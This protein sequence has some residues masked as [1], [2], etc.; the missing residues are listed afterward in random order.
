MVWREGKH[1]GEKNDRG[2]KNRMVEERKLSQEVYNESWLETGE[3]RKGKE[4]VGRIRRVSLL[5]KHTM[6]LSL[7]SCVGFLPPAPLTPLFPDL[8]EAYLTITGSARSRA[9]GS[10]PFSPSECRCSCSAVMGGSHCGGGPK[11]TGGLSGREE[12]ME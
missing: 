6:S 10:G 2:R 3:R 7:S 12:R 1:E 8:E 11:G 9:A 5:V 4:R